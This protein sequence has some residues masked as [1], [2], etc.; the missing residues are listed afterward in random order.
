MDFVIWVVTGV[1]AG[2]VALLIVYRSIPRDVLGWVGALGIGLLGGLL[3][4]WVANLLG[5]EAANWL[6]SFVI[7][8]LAALGILYLVRK[9]GISRT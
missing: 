9:A 8:L 4:G 1:L 6:G 5:L 2:V 3:G 7:A